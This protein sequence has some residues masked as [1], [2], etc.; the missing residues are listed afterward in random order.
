MKQKRINNILLTLV[1][2]ISSYVS[3]SQKQI[4][5]DLQYIYISAFRNSF[6]QWIECNQ[7]FSLKD[8]QLFKSQP[9]ENLKFEAFSELRNFLNVYKKINYYSPNNSKFLDLFS[10]EL[11][12]KL[13]NGKIVYQGSESDQAISFCNLRKKTWDRIFFCGS[14]LRIDDAIWLSNNNFILVGI[15][16]DNTIQP[17]IIV[18]DITKAQLYEYKSINKKCIQKQKYLSKKLKDIDIKY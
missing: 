3:F 10:Y 18:G 13:K 8:F 4:F 1:L 7:N 15:L 6:S 9:F 16:R 14:N 12:L 17:L 2:L 11:N 5:N